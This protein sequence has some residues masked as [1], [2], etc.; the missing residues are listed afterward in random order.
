[1]YFYP[2][3]FQS[4]GGNFYDTGMHAIEYGFSAGNEVYMQGGTGECI[5]SIVMIK[6]VLHT[7][8]YLNTGESCSTND[9]VEVVSTITYRLYK[10]SKVFGDMRDD[11]FD[12]EREVKEFIE[13][14]LKIIK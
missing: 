11:I 8:S 2:K 1:M 3:F 7:C 6:E 9:N 13:E 5:G 4:F 10:D 14:W 12:G